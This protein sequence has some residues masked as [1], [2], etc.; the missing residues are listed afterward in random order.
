ML[1]MDTPVTPVNQDINRSNQL[2]PSQQL[3]THALWRR[4]CEIRFFMLMMSGVLAVAAYF[5]S[6]TWVKVMQN[7]DHL[8]ILA[9]SVETLV[10][11]SSIIMS[12]VRLARQ[13][14]F[15]IAQYDISNQLEAVSNQL[16]TQADQ[17]IAADPTKFLSLPSVIY[18][19]PVRTSE[20]VR[21]HDLESQYGRDHVREGETKG[22]GEYDQQ[23]DATQCMVRFQF[24]YYFILL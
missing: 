13:E 20:T 7:N 21:S 22:Y 14:S 15:W 8:G 1:T 6:F 2:T 23:D 18:E 12:L 17:I 19:S 24:I 9:I 4:K 3:R 10:I 5:L 16:T 11:A